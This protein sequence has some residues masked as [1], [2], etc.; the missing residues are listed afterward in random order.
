MPL[1]NAMILREDATSEQV[2]ALRGPFDRWTGI[3]QARKQLGLRPDKALP[4]DESAALR[5]FGERR[6]H[7]ELKQRVAELAAGHGWQTTLEAPG[8]GFRV[9]VLLERDS[10]RVAVEVQL[11][12]CPIDAY[13]ERT[14]RY[15]AAGLE[16]LWLVGSYPEKLM[17]D[18]GLPLFRVGWP[19]EDGEPYLG[20]AEPERFDR[21]GRV[22]DVA[23]RPFAEALPQLLDSTIRFRAEATVQPFAELLGWTSPCWKCETEV[24]LWDTRLVGRTLCGL[25]HVDGFHPDEEWQDCFSP[26]VRALAGEAGLSDSAI[27]ERFSRT[28][29]RS[30]MSFGCPSCDAIYGEFFVRRDMLDV[31]YDPPI[32]GQAQAGAP[33]VVKRPHW[34]AGDGNGNGNYCV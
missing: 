5:S 24:P 28:V 1:V 26:A 23:A 3:R 31:V 4:G 34:C 29:G 25:A 27:K 33:V 19:D 13:K 17:P 16:S 11:S 22:V 32:F 2:D 12:S 6:A 21:R 15:R 8:D 20:F 7:A 30:Y 9:D 14:A 18:A 10:R